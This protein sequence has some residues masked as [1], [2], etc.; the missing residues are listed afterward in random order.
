MPADEIEVFGDTATELGTYVTETRDGEHID[1]G[2]YIV[3]WKKRTNW[4][5]FFYQKPIV[6]T[7]ILLSLICPSKTDFFQG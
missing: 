5:R 7:T 3:I 4:S 1:H 2:N 6:R